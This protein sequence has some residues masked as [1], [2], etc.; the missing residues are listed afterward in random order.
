MSG[1]WSG[2]LFSSVMAG[3]WL[4][5]MSCLLIAAE[6]VLPKGELMPKA[7]RWR[8]LGFMAIFIPAGAIV[9]RLARPYFGDPLF[10]LGVVGVLVFPFAWDFFYYWLHRAQHAFPLLW[11]FHAVHHSIE[12]LGAGSGYHHFAEAPLRAVAVTIPLTFLVDK[13][14]LVG[15]MITAHGLYLHSAIR[16]HFG[17]FAWVIADNRVHRLHHS[18]EPKHFDKNFGAITMLW[19]RLFGTAYFP[20]EEWPKVGLSDQRE[21]Q[22]LREFALQPFEPNR[23]FPSGTMSARVQS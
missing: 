20:G 15:M 3:A 8:A 2:V 17:R 5:A 22:S 21:P 7:A 9:S 4:A 23:Q 12:H 18:L 16:V 14:L 10:E 1:F 6:L 13:P 11:R 19:D